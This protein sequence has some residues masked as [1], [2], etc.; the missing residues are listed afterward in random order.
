MKQW[1]MVGKVKAIPTALW[2]D[3]IT[4]YLNLM[5]FKKGESK[6]YPKRIIQKE[7]FT[8]K[9]REKYYPEELSKKYFLQKLTLLFLLD[10]I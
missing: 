7:R 9:S 2:N 1:F 3:K 6:F 10:F 8:N 5:S 4:E